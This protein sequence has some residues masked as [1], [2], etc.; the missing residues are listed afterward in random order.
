MQW[1]KH[2][3]ETT[4]DIAIQKII[5]KFGFEGYGRFWRLL[6][7]I[8]IQMK[9]D[10]N[11]KPE[12]EI[13]KKEL[14]TY[15]KQKPNKLDTY[16]EHIGNVLGMNLEAT[17]SD[18]IV[19]RI[20]YPN[21][22][23]Y[24]DNHAF[25][26]PQKRHEN[27]AKSRIKENRHTVAPKPE[28]KSAKNE[29]SAD[30]KTITQLLK[31]SILKIKPDYNSL[32]DRNWNKTE[33]NWNTQIDLML[34]VDKKTLNVSRKIIEWLPN[35]PTS[36]DGFSWKDVILSARKFRTKFDKLELAMKKENKNKYQ[37][38]FTKETYNKGEF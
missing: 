7:L 24:K 37:N 28:P 1:F 9:K 34:R 18:P 5:S 32:Q 25:K 19:L 6:E 35:A 21:L 20:T 31:E 36:K 26:S 3:V 11:Y 17:E 38:Q 27:D 33:L 22:L 10:K 29:F 2:Y 8:A 13:T 16:L 12:L 14:C 4:N 15:L 30:V 23:K